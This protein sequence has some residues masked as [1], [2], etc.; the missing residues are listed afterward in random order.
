MIEKEIFL[1][2]IDV[3]RY[4]KEHD[5]EIIDVQEICADENYKYILTFTKK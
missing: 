3:M 2:M 1:T 4:T 5:V